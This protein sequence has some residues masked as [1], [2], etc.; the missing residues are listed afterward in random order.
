MRFE[1][2]KTTS[3]R[4]Q[5]R[6]GLKSVAFTEVSI[7]AGIDVGE[8]YLNHSATLAYVLWEHIQRAKLGVGLS[9]AIE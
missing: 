4:S 2:M 5:T 7:N 6:S 3:N 8:T 1:L 9:K